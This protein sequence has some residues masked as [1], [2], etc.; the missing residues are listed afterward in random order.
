MTGGGLRNVWG[1]AAAS[2]VTAPSRS[3]PKKKPAAVAAPTPPAGTKGRGTPT[4][5][6]ADFLRIPGRKYPNAS[7]S[8]PAAAAAAASNHNGVTDPIA[9]A[10]GPG[11]MGQMMSDE[12]MARM[13]QDELFQEELRN[14]PE[15]SHLAGRRNP[16]QRQATGRSTYSGGG[17][18]AAG[19]RQQGGADFFDRM[20]ELGDNAKSRFQAFA[21]RWNDNNAQPNQPK[22]GLFGVGGGNA[23]PAAAAQTNANRGGNER[24]GLLSNDLDMDEEEEEMDFVG[25]GGAGGRDFEMNAVGGSYDKKKD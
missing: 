9:S 5:L 18:G 14:N 12:Q 6:P 8:S 25:S 4:V 2:T 24:T 19:S 20:A 17:G 3:K 15:F 10:A 7:S 21:E 11:A 16:S 23:A 13:L 1:G 22:R